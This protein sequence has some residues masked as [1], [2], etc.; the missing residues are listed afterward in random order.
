MSHN[1][2]RQDNTGGREGASPPHASLFDD[3]RQGG[4]ELAG[5][6]EAYR[7]RERALVLGV[8]RG[9]VPAAAEVAVA[10]GLPLD[11][12]VIKRL[13]A[14][15]G[16]LHPASAVEVCGTL[17]LDDEVPP[18]PAAP[19]TP[20]EHFLAG[21]LEELARRADTCRGPRPPAEVAG[22]TVLLV[23]NGVHT[24]STMLTALRALRRLRPARVVAAF[25]CASPEGLSAVAAEAD[26]AVCLATP[27]PFGHVGLWYKTFDVPEDEKIPALLAPAPHASPPDS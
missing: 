9:G 18:P 23:D 21:A 13:L 6:L 12:V 8:V 10:L 20:L 4:R 26:E 25:P 17:V 2:A 19:R 14:P 5:R 15:R 7:G 3:L 16:P 1:P 27:T 24:G 11:L 22:R